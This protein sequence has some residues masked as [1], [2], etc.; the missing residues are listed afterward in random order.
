MSEIFLLSATYEMFIEHNGAL[1]PVRIEIFKEIAC[2]N[3][4]R[5]RIW[6]QNTYNLH[7]TLANIAEEGG[8]KNELMSCDEVNREITNIIAEDI[9]LIKGK[10][11]SSEEEFVKYVKS[12]V[13]AYQE[14]F[15]E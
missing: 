12:L 3:I 5:A 14:Q 4:F 10:E 9:S 13:D 7:P 2:E 15:G 8:L 6:D 1:R 11:Y